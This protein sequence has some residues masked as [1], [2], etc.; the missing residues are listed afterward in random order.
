MYMIVYEV[1]YFEILMNVEVFIRGY[2]FY[3]RGK[4]F[5]FRVEI[6]ESILFFSC[7]IVYKL[8]VNGEYLWY[9]KFF[10]YLILFNYSNNSVRR[11]RIVVIFFRSNI[12]VELGS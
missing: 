12:I 1:G 6:L 9:L 7:G 8:L 5:V 11:V 3:F 4:N 2:C 10:I